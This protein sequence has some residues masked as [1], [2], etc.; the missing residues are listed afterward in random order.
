MCIIEKNPS[1][2]KSFKNRLECMQRERDFTTFLQIQN[3]QGRGESF[4]MFT[5]DLI[6]EE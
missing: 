4:T 5:F 2:Q 3:S 6:M 1:N